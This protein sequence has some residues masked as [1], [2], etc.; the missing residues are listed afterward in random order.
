MRVGV[1]ARRA[2][3]ERR[4]DASGRQTTGLTSLLTTATHN[5]MLD[6]TIEFRWKADEDHLRSDESRLKKRNGIYSKTTIIPSATPFSDGLSPLLL[7][8]LPSSLLS[9]TGQRNVYCSKSGIS[10]GRISCFCFD[11][12]TYRRRRGG[13]VVV[14]FFIFRYTNGIERK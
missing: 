9:S 13:G 10:R 5:A 4:L 14:Q 7:L 11:K 8:L 6:R 12:S 1:C 2:V 3:Y